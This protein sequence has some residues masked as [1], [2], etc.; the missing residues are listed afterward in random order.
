MSLLLLRMPLNKATKEVMPP[1]GLAYHSRRRGAAVLDAAVERG[2]KRELDSILESGPDAV[3]E[4]D[5]PGWVRER[6]RSFMSGTAESLIR[7]AS[8]EGLAPPRW[9]L[10]PLGMYR[11]MFTA[12]KGSR[13]VPVW[14]DR[15]AGLLEELERNRGMGLDRMVFLGRASGRTLSAICRKVSPLGISW[16]SCM[17]V[18]GRMPLEGMKEAGC[19]HIRKEVRPGE[20]TGMFREARELGIKTDAVFFLPEE[21]A[22]EAAKLA[23]KC[24]PDYLAF[25]ASGKRSRAAGLVG[26]GMFYSRPGKASGLRALGIKGILKA[27]GSK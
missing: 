27:I 7:E 20:G 14:I 24:S 26:Y 8:R 11:A 19:T 9:E 16:I 18:S 15:R 17:D 5:A 10:F 12:R 6:C 22:A 3:V 1:A 2:W 25:R 13:E 4:G 23:V 21:G